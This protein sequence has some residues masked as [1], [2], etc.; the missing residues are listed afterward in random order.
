MSETGFNAAQW[1]VD[2]HVEEGRGDRV[3]YRIGDSMLSYSSLQKETWR[4]AGMLQKL[5]IGAGQRVVMLVLDEPAFPAVFLGA[6]RLGVVPI[7]VSTM[8]RPEEVAVIAADSEA[9]AAVLSAPFSSYLEPVSAAAPGLV[10]AVVVDDEGADETDRLIGGV[11]I[12]SWSEFTTDDEVAAAD[13][14]EESEAFWLYT[15]GTTGRPKGAVHRHGDVKAV[16][17]AYGRTVLGI[18]PDDICYSIAKLF[19]AFGLGNALF[20]PLSVGASAVI[21]PEPPTPAR[22]A[23]LCAAHRPTLFFA[24]PGFCAAMADSAVEPS[25]LATVRAVVTAGETLP[26]EV[27]RR[28][29]ARFGVE[30]L[31]GIGSTEALH[32]FC[33]N[34]FGDVRPGSTG[35]VVDGYELRIVDNEGHVVDEP[36]VPGALWVRGESV[37]HGYWQRPDV[38]AETFVDGWCRTGDVYRRDAEGYYYFVGRNSDMIKAGG[39][40][41]SPAEVEAVLIEHPSVLEAAVVGGRTADGLETTIAFVVPATGQAI[42]EES[43]LGHCRDRMAAFKRPRQVHVVDALPKTA[44]G[45]IKRFALRAWLEDL[46]RSGLA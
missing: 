10:A 18:G 30:M 17:D 5:G 42:D 44:T 37:T 7:P 6:L 4:A 41:V 24:P 23:E 22:A 25:A 33:S 38:N 46:S 14:T 15:S 28:F 16:C 29:R 20:L 9:R 1:L 26:A 36:D 43:L 3:A 31:D 11:S 12:R 35:R 21:D 13:K 39:I 45:K 34:H 27:Y 8:L 19:F 32:I 40:W 2:R